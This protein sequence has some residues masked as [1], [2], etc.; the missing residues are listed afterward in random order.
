MSW[1]AGFVHVY[2]D[3]NWLWW[4]LLK[5]SYNLLGLCLL[6]IATLGWYPC[7]DAVLYRQTCIYIYILDFAFPHILVLA[8]IVAAEQPVSPC[9]HDENSAASCAKY[10]TCSKSLPPAAWGIDS[11]CCGVEQESSDS[12]ADDACKEHERSNT[13]TNTQ[14]PPVDNRT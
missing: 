2:R 3:P 11:V 1:S 8:V 5:L 4:R 14:F 9:K 12:Y 6:A 10:C 13:I 7:W